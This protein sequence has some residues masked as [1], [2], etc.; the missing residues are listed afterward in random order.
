MT[1]PEDKNHTWSQNETE[2]TGNGKKKEKMKEE[3]N[4]KEEEEEK[5]KLQALV[6]DILPSTI[7]VFSSKFQGLVTPQGPENCQLTSSLWLVLK[8]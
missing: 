4:E 7:A 6:Y 3:K 5:A 1:R 2:W 8:Q